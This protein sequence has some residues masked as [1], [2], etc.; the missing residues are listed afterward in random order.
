MVV[1]DINSDFAKPVPDFHTRRLQLSCSLYQLDQLST[2][3]TM[4]TR[5]SAT[6]ID[7][8]FANNPENI[9]N[10]GVIH[11]GISDHSMIFAVKNITVPK[12]KNSTR[13]VRDYKI[14]VEIDII[15]QFDDPN[16]CWQAWKSLFLEILDRHAPVRC[17]RI[18]DNSRSVPWISSNVKKLMRNR[19]FN[20]KE[21]IK[22]AS[23]AHWSIYKTE[24]NKVNVAMRNAKKIYFR[25]KIN[26]CSES[27]DV[28]RSWNLINTLLNRNKKS[29]NVNELHINDSVVVDDKQIADAF[30]EYFVQIGP[31]LAAE[32]DDPTSQP[33]NGL[34]NDTSYFGQRLFLLKL[35]KSMLPQV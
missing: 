27:R 33:T 1:G 12:F 16:V 19:D 21:A 10:S 8:F 32:V 34:D 2:E 24:R 35:A 9:S 11:L 15:C 18:R 7:L 31:K 28:K 6:V 13:E 22:H 26:E 30:N 3:P 25:D 23:P 5:M 17:K 20:K 14:S 29:T 4:V